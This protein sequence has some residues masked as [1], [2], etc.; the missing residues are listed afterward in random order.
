MKSADNLSQ[1]IAALRKKMNMTQSDLACLL[2]VSTQAVSKWER[3]ISYPDVTMLPKIAQIFG[4]CI[5][6]LFYDEKKRAS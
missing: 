1:N 4:V 2:C 3:S 5:D 6:Y